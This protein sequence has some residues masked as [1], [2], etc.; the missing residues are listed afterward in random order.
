MK[1]KE[2]LNKEEQLNIVEQ[3]P[4]DIKHIPRSTL[5]EA[6]EIRAVLRFHNVIY[7]YEQP[8]N[9]AKVLAIIKSKEHEHFKSEV[10]HGLLAATY[11]FLTRNKMNL[12][13][14]LGVNE[15]FESFEEMTLI[16]YQIRNTLVTAYPLLKEVLI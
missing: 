10:E 5:F 8:S 16:T 12:S 6:T 7:C 2:N 13:R 9:S 14:C 1:T 3:E 11:G 15:N 4:T